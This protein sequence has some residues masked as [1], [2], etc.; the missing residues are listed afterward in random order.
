MHEPIPEGPSAGAYCPPEELSG[1]LDAYYDLRGW[2]T[3]G[4]PTPV[5][6][7]TLGL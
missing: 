6:L 4:V 1:M 5:R 2:S 7:A 3:D